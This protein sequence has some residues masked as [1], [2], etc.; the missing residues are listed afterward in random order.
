MKF[1]L[2]RFLINVER[3]KWNSEYRVYVSN[4]SRFKDEYKKEL[5][6]KVSRGYCYVKTYVGLKSAHRL[7]MMTWRPTR[8]MES[9]T[10][11]HLDHNTRNNALT[12]LEWVTFA[13][14]QKRANQ[15]QVAATML[16]APIGKKLTCGKK[17]IASFDNY[18]EAAE[19]VMENMVSEV[20]KPKAKIEQI[21]RKIYNAV[22]NKKTYYGYKWKWV[23]I[24]E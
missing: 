24:Y 2:P 19:Y 20:D 4:T 16:G 13:E 8:D 17:R 10:V 1:I 7:V 9:L 12:N 14:N 15:D 23:D 6:L 3:W 11:D 22:T 18:R 5:S 21:E